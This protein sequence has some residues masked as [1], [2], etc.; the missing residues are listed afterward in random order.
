MRL[1]WTFDSDKNSKIIE[2]YQKQWEK[3]WQDKME[4]NSID[5][6]FIIRYFTD[7]SVDTEID[8][9]FDNNSFS[10]LSIFILIQ[11]LILFTVF[12]VL[13][14]NGCKP[15]SFSLCCSTIDR[16]GTCGIIIKIVETFCQSVIIGISSVVSLTS[17]MTFSLIIGLEMNALAIVLLLFTGATITID[18]CACCVDQ[19]ESARIRKKENRVVK[20]ILWFQGLNIYRLQ[21]VIVIVTFIITIYLRSELPGIQSLCLLIGSVHC[22]NHS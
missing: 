1:E 8:R 19:F 2:E 20:G 16:G 13:Q 10:L 6:G 4:S 12:G 9:T 21:F 14:M 5:Q 11:F 7:Q 18:N 15:Q 3:Y 22:F 17:A